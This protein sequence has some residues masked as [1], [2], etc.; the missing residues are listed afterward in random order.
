MIHARTC[1]ECSA[2]IEVSEGYPDWCERCEWNVLPPEL[3]QWGYGDR[4][5]QL[6]AAWGRRSGDRLSARLLASRDLRPHWTPGRVAAYAIALA[7]IV[8]SLV[9]MGAAVA[10]VAVARFN[11]LVLLLAALLFGIGWF[12]RPRL[13]KLDADAARL[14]VSPEDAPEIHALTGDVARALGVRGPHVIVLQPEFNAWWS[15]LGWRRRRVLMLGSGLLAVLSPEELVALIG[16]EIGHARNGDAREGLIVGSAVDGLAELYAL[17]D[18]GN[19]GAA[20]GTDPFVDA[21]APLAKALQ[22]LASLPVLGLLLALAHL[23]L[24][25]MRR[26]EFLADERAA[27]VAG[28]AAVVRLHERLLLASAYALALQ[29]AAHGAGADGLFVPLR[30]AFDAVPERERA[31]RRAVARLEGTRLDATHPPTAMRIAMLEGR[32]AQPA[33]ITL[34]GGRRARLSAELEA[35][36]PKLAAELLDRERSRHYYG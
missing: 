28:S 5:D 7:V 30:A 31:R 17:M 6:L 24:G 21:A 1:P 12:L 11:L 22:R 33:K 2:E 16:H 35:L 18:A 13:G 20:D 10:A 25:D 36:E 9:L 15:V 4:F 14:A 8:T 32:P 29:R 26:A 3:P 34:D 27:Q 19:W 23:L